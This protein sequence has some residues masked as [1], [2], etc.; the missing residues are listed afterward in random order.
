MKKLAVILFVSLSSLSIAQSDFSLSV[1]SG[2]YFP[3]NRIYKLGVGGLLSVH[4]NLYN[5]FAFTLTSGYTTWGY[6]NTEEYNTKLIP[7]ILGMRYTLTDTYIEP[8]LSGEFQY[9]SGESFDYDYN[10]MV[11]RPL[12]IPIKRTKHIN[13]YGVGFGAGILVPI[14]YKLELDFGTSALFTAKKV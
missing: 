2:L 10:D 4:Y 9:L 11:G 12:S 7:I 14:N 3:N 13:D 8:Y 1:N 5:D 6:R